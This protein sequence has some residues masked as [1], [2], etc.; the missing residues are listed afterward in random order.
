MYGHGRQMY[1]GSHQFAGLDTI[2]GQAGAPPGAGGP[3]L[4][5]QRLDEARELLLGFGPFP[6]NQGATAVFFSSPQLPFRPSR[7]VIPSYLINSMTLLQINDIKVG[8]NSQLLSNT[9]IPASPFSELAVGVALGL[10]T[11]NVGQQVSISVTVLGAATV[12]FAAALI[13][14]SMQ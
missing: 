10:D 13:G 8:K 7:L 2:V 11:C 3:E 14:T 9:P 12:T 4:V 1:P 6:I 5:P